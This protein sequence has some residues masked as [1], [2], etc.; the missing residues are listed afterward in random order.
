MI[1][2]NRKDGVYMI[3]TGQHLKRNRTR[4]REWIIAEIFGLI[5]L[6]LLGIIWLFEKDKQRELLIAAA[7]SMKPAMEELLEEYRKKQPDITIQITYA[8]SGTLEQQIRQ[9][10]PIDVFISAAVEIMDSL[11]KDKL[12]IDKSKVD[13]LKN[14]L[15]LIEPANSKSKPQGFDDL[16]KAGIIS[17]GDPNSVPAGKYAYEVCT[18]LGIWDEMEKFII[19]GKDVTEV[20]TWVA[21]GNVDAGMVYSTDASLTDKVRIVAYAPEESHSKIIYC[22]AVINGSK[23]EKAGIEFIN[24]LLSQK[25]QE[26]FFKYGFLPVK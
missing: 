7:A 12:I 4:I 6:L 9:G 23:E 22:A 20:L 24:Y 25:A 13:I 21:S 14:Q 1:Q 10:A 15:V 11:S 5:S 3:S 8:S 19:Y 16:P 18:S 26:I 2:S 17:M